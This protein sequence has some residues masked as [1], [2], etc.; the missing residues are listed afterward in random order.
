MRSL[1]ATLIFI[2]IDVFQITV[3][4]LFERP[5]REGVRTVVLWS[6][7]PG[8]KADEPMLRPTEF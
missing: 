3:H 5:K 4:Q 7:V 6:Q 2:M 1:P 8:S